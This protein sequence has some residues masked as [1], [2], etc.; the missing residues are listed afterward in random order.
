MSIVGAGAIAL[1]FT[2]GTAAA[3]TRG[4]VGGLGVQ[5]P[6][7]AAPFVFEVGPAVAGKK[8]GPYPPNRGFQT[9]QV[10][11]ATAG[12]FV[13]RQLT[14]MDG[15]LSFS[16]GRQRGF[17][18]F[19][20]VAQTTKSFMSVQ[21][22]AVF[23][24]GGGAL[25]GCP[26]PGCNLDGAGT[27][28]S[29]CPPLAHNA[30]N[31]APGTVGNKAGDWDCDAWNAQLPGNRGKRFGIINEEDANHYGG[32]MNVLRNTGQNVWRVLVQPSTPMA[33]NAQVERSWMSLM[34]LTWTP[35][36]PNFE[37]R[38]NPGNNGPRILARLGTGDRLGQVIQT[39]GCAN[40]TGTIGVGKTFMLPGPNGPF[41]PILGPGNNCGTEMVADNPGQ[42]WGFK[43]TTGTISGSDFFPFSTETTALGSPFNP[44]R[45]LNAAAPF[46]FTRMG[47]DSV[48]GTARN[49]VLIG[50][51]ISVDPDSGNSFDRI[52]SLTMKLQVP[53]PSAAAGLL[54]GTAAI[55]ALA[56][57][58]R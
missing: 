39:F 30:A 38:T 3:A 55:V 37:F 18:A 26:G 33:N 14:L 27:A 57:R 8:I 44:Q 54:A 11:G 58:R 6:S 13:G 56:R 50:G 53:E 45:V 41:V 17:P 48:V 24:I 1:L 7:V 42:G 49:L 23:Q 46:F 22:G 40:G 32:T 25:A 36:R 28:I 35:G 34:N 21:Q 47:D 15:Q 10:A 12:T 43:M 29:F 9:V 51:A 4:M 31:P 2:A 20:T 52:L 19:P 5:N 16:G